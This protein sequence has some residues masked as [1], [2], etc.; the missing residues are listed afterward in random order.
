MKKQL[1]TKQMLKKLGVKSIEEIKGNKGEEL[2]PILE[3]CNSDTVNEVIEKFTDFN[4]TILT[5]LES[6]RVSL[7]DTIKSNE[8]SL[9]HFYQI[10]DEEMSSLKEMLKDENLSFEEKKEI[11]D[12]MQE[13]RKAVDKKQAENAA[14]LASR[15]EAYR[16]L[17]CLGLLAVATIVGKKYISLPS[18][19]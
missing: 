6:Y 7:N 13:L 9:N 2:I 3:Q 12:R 15:Q 1:T 18:D 14:F 11:L 16:R 10:C 19:A 17:I 8:I 5:V 4:K